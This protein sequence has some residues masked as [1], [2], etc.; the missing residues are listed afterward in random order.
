MTMTRTI[1]YLAILGILGFHSYDPGIGSLRI[2]INNLVSLLLLY[3]DT[4]IGIPGLQELNNQ[5]RYGQYHMPMGVDGLASLACEAAGQGAPPP[6][7]PGQ[8]QPPH[9]LR[10][11]HQPGEEAGLHHRL[12]P[13][14]GEQGGLRQPHRVGLRGRAAAGQE[15]GLRG[16]G[17]AAGG[18]GA[19]AAGEGR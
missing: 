7:P 12:L 1:A 14:A 6:G 2:R 10:Q 8:L 9:R 17:P 15:E 16:A 4:G 13:G 5:L 11:L 19:P 18:G 3:W